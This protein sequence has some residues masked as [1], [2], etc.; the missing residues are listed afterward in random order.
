V[1]VLG[2]LHHD[3]RGLRSRRARAGASCPP[4]ARQWTC[5]PQRSRGAIC[6]DQIQ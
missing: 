2:G 5:P 6:L 4:A 3:H 1:P